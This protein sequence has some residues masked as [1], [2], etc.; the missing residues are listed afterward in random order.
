RR[1]HTRFSR[2]WSSD[3]CS[4]D[5]SMAAATR[6]RQAGLPS[7][8]SKLSICRPSRSGAWSGSWILAN[9]TRREVVRAAMASAVGTEGVREA[10]KGC[11]S[12]R[13]VCTLRRRRLVHAARPGRRAEGGRGGRW[14]GGG[15]R[16][17]TAYTGGQGGVQRTIALRSRRRP[18]YAIGAVAGSGGAPRVSQW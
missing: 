2:D 12:L 18:P 14:A 3:V 1:R 15:Q 7:S 8:Q 6:S 11:P 17:A 13:I 5:L 9:E 10:A 4:S 16:K